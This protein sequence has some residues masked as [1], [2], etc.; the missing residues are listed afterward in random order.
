M[1]KKKKCNKDKNYNVLPIDS[2]FFH[3]NLL[4]CKKLQFQHVTI[5]AP[6]NS[7]NTDGIHMGH[8]SQITITNANIGTGD[9]CISICD[10]TQDFTANEVTCGPG[11]GISIG[12]LGKVTGATLSNTDNGVRIKTLPSSSSRVA[13][14]IHFE[15]VVMKNVGNPI[16]INQNYCLNNQCSNQ[17]HFKKIR[18]TSSTKK[19][20]N[21]ICT[22]SVPCQQ[23]VLSD[24]DLAY[25]GGG[26]STTSTF[27]NVQH[28]IL[29][30]QNPPACI[31]KH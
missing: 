16:I 25:K 19:V 23:V 2:K 20:V 5:I 24:I 14:D 26:G 4:E 6:A 7:L 30:K 1:V 22:K 12:S 29:G 11:H 13:S 10:G 15:D 27:T 31:N 18:G 3:I 28:A 9:D 17:R 8:S 21:L